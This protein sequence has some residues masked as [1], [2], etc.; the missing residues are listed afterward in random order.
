ESATGLRS[1]F[2]AVRA[3]T[4]IDLTQI[5]QGRAVADAFATAQ[6]SGE[7]A[8]AA[9]PSFPAPTTTPAAPETEG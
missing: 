7:K 4:G 8:P 3:A 2:E 9:A 5:I 6:R 1:S